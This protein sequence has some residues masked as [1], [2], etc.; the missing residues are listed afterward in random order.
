MS[1]SVAAAAPVRRRLRRVSLMA[2]VFLRW[3]F[4]RI[5][6]VLLIRR[7]SLGSFLFA[8]QAD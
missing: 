4:V 8:S 7:T 2:I 1:G 6:S 5:D 3:M